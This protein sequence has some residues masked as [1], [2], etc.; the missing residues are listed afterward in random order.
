MM[1]FD[2]QVIRRILV[3]QVNWV[4]DAVLTLPALEALDGR[5]PLAE[6]TLL[7]RPWVAGLFAGHPALDRMIEYRSEDTHRGL[8]GRWH[9]AAT[10]KAGEFDLAV[11][12]PNSME[13]AVVP[14]LAG[15]PRRIGHPT[16]G[17]RCLLT[18]VVSNESAAGRH[19]VEWYLDVARALGAEGTRTVRLPVT[20]AVRRRSGELLRQYGIASTGLL[21]ALNPGSA[22]GNAKRWAADRFAAV[23]DR[24]VESRGAT[25][26]LIGSEGERPVLDTVAA[27][28]RRP[29][30][31]L[32]GCTDLPALVGVLERANLLV[33]NDTGAM[34]VAVAVGTPVLAIFG[35]TDAMATGPLG[36]CA[37]VVCASVPCSPCLLRECPIDHRC[38]AGVTVPQVLQAATSLLDAPPG[39]RAPIAPGPFG[40]QWVPALGT[41][42]AFLDRDGT[43]I[44]DPGYLRDPEKLQFI[45]GAIEALR[46]LQ[47]AG[48]RLVLVSNQAG[49]ARGLL[50]ETDVHRVN[51]RLKALLAEVGVRLDGIY[52]C[53]H[54]PDYG[55][56]EY[57]REC[58][59]RKPRPGLIHRAIRDLDLNPHRSVVIGDHATDAALAG[60]FPGMV[61][62]MLRTGHGAE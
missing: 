11:L 32:G 25:I 28:M 16:D 27:H 23:A 54:H 50:T 60:A 45:P 34:H 13:A 7:A 52:F 53:P 44:E 26:L 47:R 14:W 15:I 19:Q 3:R 35:P 10:V 4:G 40:P 5:F 29:S 39:A 36:R 6:I 20:E 1:D 48:Y 42:A 43:I 49:V 37:R 46:G 51:D 57:R 41:P 33:S 24:L 56:P 2:P 8:R 21:V 62:I 17:R 30:V 18:H 31:N 38:M 58:D 22:Y 59:C 12:F 61:G 9:L 55:P